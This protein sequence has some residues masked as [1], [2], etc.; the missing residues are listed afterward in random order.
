MQPFQ[1]N[2]LNNNREMFIYYVKEL[3]INE[4]RYRTE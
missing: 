3:K 4:K 2:G 1:L